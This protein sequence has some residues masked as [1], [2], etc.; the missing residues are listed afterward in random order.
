MMLKDCATDAAHFF[1]APSRNDLDAVF[2]AIKTSITK[3]R[4]A[5]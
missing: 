4:L 1:D 3:V 2:K 5:S